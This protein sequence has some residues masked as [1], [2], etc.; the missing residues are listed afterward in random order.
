[1]WRRRSRSLLA[2]L[3][4]FVSFGAACRQEAA[5]ARRP[6]VVVVA[7]DS[8]R[9]DHLDLYG[10]LRA[11]GTRLRALADDGIT[12]TNAY[13][14]SS[15]TRP[16]VASLLTGE[17]P[18]ANGRDGLASDRFT[19]AEYL[20]R[21][22]YRSVVVSNHP[23]LS[24]DPGFLQGFERVVALPN[25]NADAAVAAAIA[26]LGEDAGG[27]PLLLF[28]HL[29]DASGPYAPPARYYEAWPP[30]GAGPFDPASVDATT[31]AAR[32]ADLYSAYDGEVAYVDD[33]IGRLAAAMKSAGRYDAAMMVVA[34][35]HGEELQEHGR[36]G[37]GR[38]LF[39]EVVSI[40]LV[41]KFPLQAGAGEYVHGP[42]SL[43]DVVPTVLPVVGVQTNA[44][45]DG[46]DLAQVIEGQGQAIRDRALKLYLAPVGGPALHGVVQ[47][48]D[49]LLEV[50]GD[51]ERAQLYRLPL[52]PYEQQDVAG[53][54]ATRVKR[55][56]RVLERRSAG[57]S[58]K[59]V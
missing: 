42:T 35:T 7:V 37:F 8:L 9:R 59:G 44:S 53:A 24:N 17:Y 49:K 19:L 56:R 39:E 40:P 50:D 31:P 11:T 10:Y 23:E 21:A 5:P 52:D 15:A 36:A 33:E 32:M 4:P 27:R 34:A 6:D 57:A 29:A 48:G 18:P 54:E 51:P 12:F 1:M 38:T 28:L 13:S 26:E 43:V 58:R 30:K 14:T 45:L 22:G 16:A 25:R 46:I 55:L 47:R 3:I 20:A 41:L 2:I